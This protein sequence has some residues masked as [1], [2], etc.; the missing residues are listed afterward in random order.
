MISPSPS[1][2]SVACLVVVALL[3]MALGLAHVGRRQ[4]VVA[5]AYELSKATEQQSRLEEENRRLRLEKSTLTS[6]ERLERLA[7]S[8]GLVPPAPEQV[9]VVRSQLARVEGTSP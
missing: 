3:M 5:L 8:L 4:Q 1:R 9:R 6:P 7:A 2:T